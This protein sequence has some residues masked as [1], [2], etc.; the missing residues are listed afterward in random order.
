[1]ILSGHSVTTLHRGLLFDV[2]ET[3]H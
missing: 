3:F 1:V 2:P